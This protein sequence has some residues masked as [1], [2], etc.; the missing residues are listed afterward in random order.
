MRHPETGASTTRAKVL[1]VLR[2]SAREMTITE[3]AEQLRIHPNTVRFHLDNLIER[4]QIEQVDNPPQ[5][6]GRP[7]VRVR[8]VAAMD[9]TG[10]RH[11]R[12]LAE[13][14]SLGFANGPTPAKRAQRAGRDWGG[15]L[16]DP[17]RSGTDMNDP[18]SRLTEVLGELGFAPERTA[19]AEINLRHC[20]FLELATSTSDVVC[21]VHLGL[22]QGA[23][24]AL[25]SDTTVD[26][27]DPFVR[28]DLCVAHLK[29]KDALV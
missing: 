26:R 11:Y 23:L 1:A 4:G 19:S 15:R 7:A 27:L 22:M 2:S 20:P 17:E 12:V 13:V 9:P 16:V 3:I 24:D 14:L 6:P 5:G 25:G 10:P 28:P 21:S 8:A 29:R 18:V